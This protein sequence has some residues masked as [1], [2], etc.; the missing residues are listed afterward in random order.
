MLVDFQDNCDSA[1]GSTLMDLDLDSVGL[2]AVPVPSDHDKSLPPPPPISPQLTQSG[3][4]RRQYQLPKRYLDNLPR[5]EAPLPTLKTEPANSGTATHTGIRRVILIVRDHLVTAL[6]SFGLWRDYPERPSFDPDSSLTLEDL[7][8][9]CHQ[10][11]LSVPPISNDPFNVS[12]AGASAAGARTAYWPFPNPA[13]HGVM[14]WLNNGK[15][16][17]SEAEVTHFVHDVILSPEFKTADLIGFDAH[18]ENQRLDTALSQDVLRSQF[19]ES[20]VE[21]LVPSGDTNIQPRPFSVRGTPYASDARPSS[22][23]ASDSRLPSTPA[24]ATSSLFRNAFGRMTSYA[25]RSQPA[26]APD[27]MT[28]RDVA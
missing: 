8:A 7:T 3:R 25:T 19:K 2:C 22:A 27:R 15:T 16:A 24:P 11:H 23:S 14:K 12:A 1:N 26:S 9:L 6:N 18:Q 13:I 4:P 20:T 17:K 28:S 21:I 5:S 10:S